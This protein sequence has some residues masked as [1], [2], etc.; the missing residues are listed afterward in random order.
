MKIIVCPHCN[1]E[2]EIG[3]SVHV[4]KSRLY[5]S[6]DTS[7]EHFC[8][9][10][11]AFGA[12]WRVNVRTMTDLYN[13]IQKNG[14]ESLTRIYGIGSHTKKVILNFYED[15]MAKHNEYLEGQNG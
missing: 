6:M 11:R 14:E 9:S 10:V 15:F 7:I 4:D 2:V 8:P 1:K 5:Q 3:G 12:L 13:Y